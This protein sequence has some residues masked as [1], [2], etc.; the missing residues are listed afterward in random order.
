MEEKKE[1]IIR[2]DIISQRKE[3]EE[4]EEKI[5]FNSL[6]MLFLCDIIFFYKTSTYSAFF[7]FPFYF[8]RFSSSFFPAC[9]F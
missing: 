2:K 6:R 5:R 1:T 7:L 9:F 3:R 8:F 4:K